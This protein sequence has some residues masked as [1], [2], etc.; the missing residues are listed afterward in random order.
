ME[1]LAAIPSEVD[2]RQADLEGRFNEV[3]PDNRQTTM[4][5]LANTRV[6]RG[7]TAAVTTLGVVEAVGQY[8]ATDP[9]E[10]N[11]SVPTV[12]YTEETRLTTVTIGSSQVSAEAIDSGQVTIVGNARS[13]S[14]A[15]VKKA[16]KAGDCDVVSGKKAMQMGI[17]TQ[18]YKGT[19][20]GY[21][22][23]NR[24]ST[25][26]DL[27][28]DGDYDV[29]AE[30]GNKTTRVKPK[31]EEA[32]QV[33][34]ANSIGKGSV[35]VRSTVKILATA[36]CEGNSSRA[37]ATAEGS[38]T[39]E[40]RASLKVIAKANGRGKG[41]TLEATSH[42]SGA[43][44]VNA[45]ADASG[46]AVAICEDK[47]APPPPPVENCETNPKLC[48]PPENCETNPKLC[49]P[50]PANK[51]PTGRMP[52]HQRIEFTT[53][54]VCVTDI[55]DPDGDNANVTNFTFT[56]RSGN[57]IGFERSPIYTLTGANTK[58]QCQDYEA[59]SAFASEGEVTVD[60]DL[61]DGKPGGQTAL[62]NTMPIVADT[63]WE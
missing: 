55:A 15:R 44:S 23:E 49:P 18:G 7:I 38:A 48:P 21:A 25:L 35:S 14:K 24:K 5:R 9:A 51:P 50:P 63:S 22:W 17:K 47:P 11:G 62:R 26:C 19:G 13:V 1:V 56:N 3:D 42:V 46:R 37:W 32:K 61:S 59:P 60:A 4:T 31:P 20:K 41:G 29:R 10:A 58:T 8:V 30:C 27:D 34:W 2:L 54:K 16:M 28:G 52:L 43:A 36:A 39:A 6:G 40:G 53:D 57:P 45:K 12:N 33:V